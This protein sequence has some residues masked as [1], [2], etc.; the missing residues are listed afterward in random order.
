MISFDLQPTV[1]GSLVELRPLRPED[2]EALFAAASDPLIWEVHP[3]PTRYKREVFQKFFDGGIA[4]GG[5][6]AVMD[7]KSGRII[8]SSRYHDLKPGPPSEIEIGWTFLQREFWGGRYNGEMKRLMINHALRFVDRVVFTVGENN[9]RSRK[10]LEKIGARLVGPID[11]P[12][13]DGSPNLL[14]EIK[15]SR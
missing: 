8:G 2:F 1:T 9:H 15:N 11:R 6:F 10:A 3:E 12:A 7:R 13:P 4:S 14:Y 5:A